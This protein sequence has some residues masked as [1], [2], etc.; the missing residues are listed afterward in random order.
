MKTSDV[1]IGTRYTCKV[2]HKLVVVE[3]LSINPN[4]GWN[5]KNLSTGKTIH[6]KSAQRLR[7]VAKRANT[8]PTVATKASS[9]SRRANKKNQRT[10]RNLSPT[11][12]SLLWMQPQKC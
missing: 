9:P 1:H 2:N 11:N 12:V 8:S 7:G 3:I 6:I 4:G 5:A 10:H